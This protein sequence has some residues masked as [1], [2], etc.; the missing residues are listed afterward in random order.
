MK[1]NF[2]D[3]KPE[4]IYKVGNVIKKNGDYLYLITE[5]TISKYSI[6]N[7]TRNAVIATSDSLEELIA[8]FAEDGDVL[9]NVEINEI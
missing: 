2:N 9:V 7:L 1:I 6:V 4:N 5:D 3:E 8:E